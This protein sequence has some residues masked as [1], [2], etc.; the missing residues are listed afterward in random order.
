MIVQTFDGKVRQTIF[1]NPGIIKHQILNNRRHVL[2]SDTANNVRLWDV[3]A[4]DWL[5]NDRFTG[6]N[7]HRLRSSINGRQNE[8]VVSESE[9]IELVF[10]DNGRG[11]S[12]SFECVVSDSASR[13]PSVFVCGSLRQ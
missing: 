10:G 6:R 1:G 8:R 12:S 9:H 7:D 3:I 2:T 4:V 11:F 13:V 5:R